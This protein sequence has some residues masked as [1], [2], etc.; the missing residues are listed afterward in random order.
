MVSPP[1]LPGTQCSRSQPSAGHVEGR[2]VPGSYAP[3]NHSR[4]A[5]IARLD[6]AGTKVGGADLTGAYRAGT[7]TTAGH[8]KGGNLTGCY[9]PRNYCCVADLAGDNGPT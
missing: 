7:Q 6:Y 8:V 4:V 1:Y 3:R 5:H 2:D 9:A